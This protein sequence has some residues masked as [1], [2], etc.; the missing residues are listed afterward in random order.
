[1]FTPICEVAGAPLPSFRVIRNHTSIAHSS[2]FAQRNAGPRSVF[3]D[4][5]FIGYLDSLIG[6]GG[7]CVWPFILIGFKRSRKGERWKSTVPLFLDFIQSQRERLFLFRLQ[8]CFS[9]THVFSN[10]PEPQQF[11]IRHF[12]G[13]W[14]NSLDASLTARWLRPRIVFIAA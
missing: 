7:P 13:G 6:L 11:G 2:W 12:A 5:G 9:G 4:A 10:N 8:I 3:R 1:M 14:T